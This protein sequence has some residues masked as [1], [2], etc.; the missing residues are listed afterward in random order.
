MSEDDVINEAHAEMVK[1]LKTE[2]LEVDSIVTI[3]LFKSDDDER[4]YHIAQMCDDAVQVE[5]FCESA[6]RLE[7]EAQKVAR[8]SRE[9]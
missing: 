9:H 3:V 2:G 1:R 8:E 7:M 5:L 6:G 4:T